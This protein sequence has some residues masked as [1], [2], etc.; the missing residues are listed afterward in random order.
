VAETQAPDYLTADD[1]AKISG[2]TGIKSVAKDSIIGA[3]GTYNF[4]DAGNKLVLVVKIETSSLQ[5]M[6]KMMSNPSYSKL[7][8]KPVAGL[9]DL[10]Y[11][12]PGMGLL[13][14]LKGTHWI[15]ITSQ[16]ETATMKYILTSAQLRA[17][18]ARIIE[19]AKW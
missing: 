17:V 14:A 5:E 19:T 12:Q 9:G 18:Y 10:G 1:V 11:E 4:A 7:Y 2:L 16:M 8:G 15:S 3:L 6:Q 13:A